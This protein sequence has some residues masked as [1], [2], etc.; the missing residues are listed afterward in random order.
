MPHLSRLRISRSPYIPL[1]ST[2]WQPLRGQ[3]AWLALLIFAGIGLQLLNPLLIR[4]FLDTAAAGGDLRDLWG[5]AGLFISS[6]LLY[7]GIALAQTWLAEKT[8]WQATNALRLD[9]TDHCLHL[10]MAFHNNRTP[11]ELIERIDGDVGGLANLFARFALVIVANSLLLLGI[12]A[13]LFWEDW[14]IGLPLLLFVLC[15]LFTTHYV[16][17]LAGPSW[18]A[19]REA[20]ARLLGFLEERLAGVEEI[21]AN[22][23]TA[24]ML[25]GLYRH[26]RERFHS[27]RRAYLLM[28]ATFTTMLGLIAVGNV[29]ALS[30]GAYLLQQQAISIG[31]VYLIF[32]Y[33]RLLIQPLENL[34]SQ[35][36][37]LPQSAASIARIE[38]LLRVPSERA[39][40]GGAGLP[41]GPLA[42]EFHK[43]AFRYTATT[44]DLTLRDLSFHLPAGAVLGVAGRTGSGKTTLTRLLTRLYEPTAG[45]IQVG[46]V[47]MRQ[48]APATLRRQI[49][50]VTQDVQ[51]LQASVRDNLTFFD[52]TIP[53]EQILVA[54]RSLGLGD[55]YGTLPKGLDTELTA[56]GMGLSAGEAQLLAFTRVLL[57]DPGLVILDEASARL[58]PLTERLINQAIANLL[59]KGQRTAIII[60]HRLTTLQRVDQIMILEQGAVVEYG[61]REQ[62]AN[63]PTSRFAQLL[64]INAGRTTTIEEVLA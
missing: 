50:L 20:L 41:P 33:T 18:Q 4:S 17:D 23:A 16:R 40:T 56:G 52:P 15:A 3:V 24:Y 27:F 29:V 39:L 8:A 35:L 53:D 44:A 21:R 1:L 46:G 37:D 9:L 45:V 42:V 31:T 11:G 25:L 10:A 26:Q 30:V 57:K 19:A 22:G 28:V 62:L 63:E 36:N 34:I 54:L 58:D 32:H 6:A 38:E 5:A 43:V 7:Q 13:T 48:L 14:R 51:L 61:N 12:L 2:Y 60:A 49:G 47:D 59:G 64:Q 55:W